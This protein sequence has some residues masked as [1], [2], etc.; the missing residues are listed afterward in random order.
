V[1]NNYRAKSLP[2]L[3]KQTILMQKVEN[4]IGIDRKFQKNEENAKIR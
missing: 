4:I 1:S 2:T 3:K